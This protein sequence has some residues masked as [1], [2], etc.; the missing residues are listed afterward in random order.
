MS[1]PTYYKQIIHILESLHKAHPTYN[2]G[3]HI[4]TALDGYPDIWGVPDKELLMSLKK[5]ETSLEMDVSHPDEE[6]IDKIIKDGMNLGGIF[7]NDI[8]EEEEY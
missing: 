5:Y 6:D 8:E 2:M 1:R 7:S 4:S 3:R